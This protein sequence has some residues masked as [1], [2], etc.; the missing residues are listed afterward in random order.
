MTCGKFIGAAALAIVLSTPAAMADE[1]MAD[2]GITVEELTMTGP[3]ADILGR[4][5][6]YP[7]G[8]PS[9]RAYRITVPPGKAT[10]LHR[11]PVPL[12]AVI[13][14][15]TLQVDYG[16]RGKRTFKPGDGFLEAVDWCHAGSAV[17]EAPVVLISIYMGD[18]K[19]QNTVECQTPGAP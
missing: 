17:G 12:Y 14:S 4:P 19:T 10:V 16:T 1:K 13:L 5:L 15:G 18:D 8:K 3:S 11:H 7:E 2:E 6:V 9:V